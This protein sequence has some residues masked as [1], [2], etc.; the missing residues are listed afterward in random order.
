MKT[1]Q[2]IEGQGYRLLDEPVITSAIAPVVRP[3]YVA[4]EEEEEEIRP[5]F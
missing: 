1:W 5:K 2:L 3:P 4:E